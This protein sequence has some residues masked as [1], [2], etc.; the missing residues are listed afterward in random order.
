[1]KNINFNEIHKQ[2]SVAANNQELIEAIKNNHTS[3]ICISYMVCQGS[4]SDFYIANQSELFRKI[5]DLV[6]TELEIENEQTSKNLKN[7]IRA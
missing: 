7:W 1:M 5:K 2:A 3:S 6:I 4:S